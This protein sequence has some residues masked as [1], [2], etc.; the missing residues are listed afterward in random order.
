M[1]SGSSVEN[2]FSKS[3]DDKKSESLIIL[4]LKSRRAI[5]H[6]LEHGQILE[7]QNLRAAIDEN[8]LLVNKELAA[9]KAVFRIKIWNP[10]P[11]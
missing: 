3:C 1:D 4:F 7:R 9:S 2:R 5:H 6:L 10:D 8:P 11:R